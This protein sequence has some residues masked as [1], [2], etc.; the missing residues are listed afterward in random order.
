MQVY[1]I[2]EVEQLRRVGKLPP[3]HGTVAELRA[4]KG[5]AGFVGDSFR[6]VR[7]K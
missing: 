4:T 5:E 6:L 2:Q 7:K 1:A 3:R